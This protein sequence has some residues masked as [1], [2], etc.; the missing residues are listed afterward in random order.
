VELSAEICQIVGF[1]DGQEVDGQMRQIVGRYDGLQQRLAQYSR[2]MGSLAEDI[3]IFL[4]STA[5]MA[6]WLDRA[7]R[8]VQTFGDL[9]IEPEELSNKSDALVEFV[10]N[11]SLQTPLLSEN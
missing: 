7:E 2:L 10:N 8:E 9:P 3:G 4:S 6:E 11:V 1:E 5:Q